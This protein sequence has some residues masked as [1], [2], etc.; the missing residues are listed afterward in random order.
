MYKIRRKLLS[1]NFIYSRKLLRELVRN[2]GITKNDTVLEIG[3]GKGLITSELLR[4]GTTVLA[5]ELD[6]KLVLHI[7]KH[8]ES[9]TN[10]FLFNQNIL[11]FELPKKKYKT[12]SNVPYSIEGKIVRKLIDDK[13]PPQDAFLIVRRDLAERLSG[14]HHEN[15]FSLK[16]KTQF[17]FSIEHYF[18]RTDFI[19]TPNVDSVLWRIKKLASP[20]IP[21]SEQQNW[22]KLIEDGISEGE[23][24]SKNLVPLFG[25]KEFY[26]LCNTL[27]ITPR[28]KP[29]YL[30]MDQWLA[31]YYFL[32][33]TPPSDHQD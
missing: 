32:K 21:E 22:E 25:D 26:K 24:L 4:K 18:K 29:S 10:L 16:H 12:F 30:T 11:D 3:P 1:Q 20:I 17:S 27:R 15:K 19:P 14:L 7:K 9:S 2:S 6:Q 23:N 33:N 13:N 28:T 5:V 31:I 8:F